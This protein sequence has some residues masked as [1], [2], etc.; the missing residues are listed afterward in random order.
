MPV[1]EIMAR[2]QATE[3]DAMAVVDDLENMHVIGVLTE[4]FAL[5]RYTEALDRQRRVL[6][7]E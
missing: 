3:T 4:Q 6:S 2:F 5:R 1:N 7:G